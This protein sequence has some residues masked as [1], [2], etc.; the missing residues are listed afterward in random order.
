MFADVKNIIFDLDGTL[1]DS[2]AGVI[3]ATNYAL[4]KMGQAPRSP[5]EIRKFIGYPLED[6]FSSFCSAP[7]DRLAEAFQE[8]GRG[9][10]T[11]STRPMPGADTIITALYYAG[12]RLA[13]ATTKFVVHTEGIVGKLG[14]D[15]YFSAL[16]SGDEVEHVKPAPD[17][18]ELAISRLKADK[19]ESI[20]IGDTVN[21]ILAARA[22]GLKVVLIASP[23]G[24]HDLTRYHPDLMLDSLDDLKDL[25]RL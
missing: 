24:N 15:R 9:T 8:K 16:A 5:D 14:W 10:I 20:V 18:V 17:L 2:S 3:E 25:F 22:A 21:D 23:F 13:I 7:L 4:V 1:I 12:Y 6:M 11:S 19:D